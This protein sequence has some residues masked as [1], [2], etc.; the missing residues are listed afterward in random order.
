MSQ[1]APQPQSETDIISGLIERGRSAMAV[2]A[3]ADQAQVDEAVTA[4]CW[5]IYKP[6]NAKALAELATWQRRR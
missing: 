6:E 5:S 1:P 4:L 3:N 2:F